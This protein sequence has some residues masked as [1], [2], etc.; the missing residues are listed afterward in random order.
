MRRL[1]DKVTAWVADPLS[2]AVLAAL[3]RLAML[4]EVE[5]IAVMP[6]VHLAEDV[7]V[8]TVVATRDVLIPAAVGGDIGCGMAAIAFD[9]GA[10][11]LADERRAALLFSRL[12]GAIPAIR[13]RI[14]SGPSLPARLEEMPLSDPSLERLKHREG[15]SEF[16]TLGRG[17]H[18]VELQADAE[19]R[20]WLMLH[21]GSRAMGQAIRD[22]H[23]RSASEHVG[24][25]PGLVAGTPAGQAYLEDVAWAIAYADASRR[26]MLE[27]ICEL[28]RDE[29]QAVADD[30]TYTPCEHNHVRPEEHG[31]RQLWVHRK[32]AISATPGEPGIIPGSM[33]SESY[34]VVGRG[35]AAALRSSSHGAGRRMSRSEASR[36]I[37]VKQLQRELRGVWYDHRLSAR[38]RDEAPSAYKDVT[39]VMRAQRELTSIVRR[40]RPVLSYKGT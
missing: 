6:D 25:L 39:Q 29:F 31:G 33:G 3:E 14:G 21:S 18:F 15:V 13:H 1:P 10:D 16:A 35:L 7:C 9:A 24:D 2:P 12:Y 11:L 30:S 19:G 37:S 20:L 28:L 4:P 8:G 23:L 36:A 17:N 38:L 26:A 32:G 34:H 5:H 27:R 40:L 22:H